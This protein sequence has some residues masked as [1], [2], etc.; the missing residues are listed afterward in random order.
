MVSR[1]IAGLLLGALYVIGVVYGTFALILRPPP[2]PRVALPAARAPLTSHLLFVVVDGLRYDVATDPERMPHF[3]AAMRERRSAEIYAGRVS[4]TSAAVQNFG[5]GQRGRFAQI[6]RNIN[7]DPPAYNSWLHNAA[8]RGRSLALAGDPVWVEMFGSSFRRQLLDPP[9]V[10]MDYDFNEQTFKNTRTLLGELPSVVVSHFVTPDHQGHVYGIPS[11]RYRKHIH[12]FDQSLFELLREVPVD[13]TVIVT[14]DHGAADS[15]THGADVKVQRRSPIFAYG[16]G[17]AAKGSDEVLDQSDLASTFAALLGVPAAA[18]SQGHVM[19]AWLDVPPALQAQYGCDDAARSLALLRASAPAEAERVAPRLADACAAQQPAEQRRLGAAAVTREIDAVLSGRQDFS[20]WQ[21]WAFLGATL[22]GAALVAWLLVGESLATA[23]ACAA[24]ALLAIALVAGLEHLPGAWPKNVDAALFVVFNLP[25]LLF[26]LR[27]ERL[28]RLLSAH[29]TF[30]AAIVPGGFAVAYPTNL[31]P[32]AFA[33][34]LVAPLVIAVSKGPET[35]GLSLRGGQASRRAAN[36]A[37]LAAWGAALLPAGISASGAYSDLNQRPLLVLGLALALVASVAWVLS[38]G[39]SRRWQ[40]WGWMLALGA[41]SLL[42]RRVAP[43]W[44]GRPLLIG[45]PLAGA[46]LLWRRQTTSG[47]WLMI[48]GFLWVSRDFEVLPVMAGLGVLALLSESFRGVS[49][50]AWSHGRWLIAIGVLFCVMFLVRLGVSA[51]LDALSLDFAAGAFDDRH[52]SA[53]WITFA[54]IW[55]YVLISVAL[56]VLALSNLPRTLAARSALALLAICA[57]R[58]AVLLGM[59][60][61]SQGS[62]WTAMRVMSDLPFALLYTVS[63]ALVLLWA[64]T[65]VAAASLDDAPANGV[66]FRATREA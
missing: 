18:H 64:E 1:R 22:V 4:M 62:F 51:G 32:V 26:L 8:E 21:A 27:P 50:E 63:A 53:S 20:S 35:W 12:D 23:A 30:A 16:P 43:A 60:Q 52:V 42:L 11:A 46:A 39:A 38:R 25:S 58:A 28:I 41:A 9:G 55:K 7:P 65:C 19:S 57:C 36:L 13:F 47:L 17:I 2:P 14:S 59:L 49:R 34:C 15:G 6:V 3:A 31:Q 48:A 56:A 45:L 61:C 33:I 54:V 40:Q 37:L 29:P 5:T 44:V 24:L 10:A 66:S